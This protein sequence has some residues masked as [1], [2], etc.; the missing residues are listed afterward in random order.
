MRWLQKL[1]MRSRAILLRRHVERE[2][3]DELAAHLEEEAGDLMRR[4]VGEAEAWARARAEM[5]RI[6]AIREECRD[7]RGTTGWEQLR[8]DAMFGIRVLVKNRTFTAMAV[9]TMALAIGSTTAVF[10]LIDALLIR[11]LP[12]PSPERLYETGGLMM[13]GPFDVMRTNSRLADYGAHLG[14]RG[15]T[16]EGRELPER[17]LGSEVSA[18]FF[19]VMG[20]APLMGRG[21]AH[22]EDR[23]GKGRVVMISHRFW[24]E[25]FSGRRDVVG[26]QLMLDETAHEIIGVMPAGFRFPSAGIS[27][28]TPMRLDPR[29]AGLYWGSGGLDAILRLKPGIS[30]GAALDELRAWM[31]RIRGMFPWRMPDAWGANP[32]LIPLQ[33][34]MAAGVKT[35]SL[36]LLGVVVLVLLIAV[37]NVATL[38]SGQMAARER[39]LALRESLGATPWRLARQLLTESV[40]LGAAAGAVGLGLAFGELRLLKHMLPADT[41]RLGEAVI[42]GRVLLF[43]A[44]VALGSGLLFGLLPA[45]RTRRKRPLF[46]G[47]GVRATAGAARLRAD[48]LLVAAEAAFATILLVGAG[49]LLHSLWTMLRMDPG[50]RAQAVVTAELSP[51]RAAVNSRQKLLSAYE[52]VRNRLLMYPGVRKVA[53]IN[54]LPLTPEISAFAA[55]IEDHP[56][57]ASAPQYVMWSSIVSPDLHD[58]LGIRV[59]EGRAFTGAD[60]SGGPQVVLVSK[61]TARRF[62][63]DRSPIGR[64]LRPVWD[65]EWRTIVGVVEDVKHHSFHGP[66]DWV[67]GEVYLPLAQS[68]GIPRALSIVARVDGDA[69]GFERQLPRMIHEACIECAA[70]RV[71]RMERMV[72][73][74]AE[75]PRLLTWLVGS[76]ALLAL[77]M[78]AAGIYGVVNH[79]VVRRTR[80]LGVRLALGASRHSIAILVMRASLGH[81]V[82]GALAGLVGAWALA[83]GMR[84][85]LFGVAEHDAL[86]FLAAPA[87]LAAFALL[88][89]LIPMVRAMRVDP[90][91]TL[92]E[93]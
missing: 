29:D 67:D 53:A 39:E 23:L 12:F 26:R 82:A 50:F 73:R 5:G 38:M 59:L 88:A 41:P 70:G 93:S 79:G 28:W 16:V 81:T 9:A 4:G 49:L 69:D 25:R 8:Q 40:V 44:A 58:T 22:G 77:A 43:T 54:V 14:V 52:A 56:R 15:F 78:A 66:P 2:M 64:R 47:D 7:A 1:S 27:F 84:T 24:L 17:L 11:P 86:S 19:D 63:P 80:E 61:S 6:E 74:A 71:E 65:K 48:G 90:A 35:K 55:G 72:A 75:S 57:P 13:R 34:S 89:C 45:W 83:K 32:Q 10:S 42:D 76:F 92:R 37:L 91:Q 31:P 33:E 85:L 18:N 46:A 36:L 20:V 3:E 87:M 21:F 30:A 62:W 60:R 51:G 68:V